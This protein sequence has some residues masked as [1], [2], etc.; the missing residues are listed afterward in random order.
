[1]AQPLD[2]RRLELT[3]Q[4][5]PVAEQLNDGRAFSSSANNVLVFQQSPAS[6]VQLAWYDREGKVL[7][8]AGDPGDYKELALSPDGM[9]LAVTKGRL[10]DTTNIWLLDLTRGGASTR[11]TF[12]SLVDASPVWSPDGSRIIYSSNRVGP[13][14]RIIE[15]VYV[16][17]FSFF[18][19]QNG[20]RHR[21]VVCDGLNSFARRYFDIYWGNP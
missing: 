11:F 6:N 18:H 19:S 15:H 1:M 13:D 21:A 12:G 2:S 4:P 14:I 10:E 16:D 5:A 9:Q 20:A 3:G 17:R 8:T 7:E